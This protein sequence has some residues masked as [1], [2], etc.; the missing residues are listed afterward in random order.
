MVIDRGLFLR[1]TECFYNTRKKYYIDDNGEPVLYELMVSDRPCFSDGGNELSDWSKAV[2]NVEAY[3]EAAE[4]LLLGKLPKGGAFQPKPKGKAELLDA[5]R[6]RARR[7][8]FDYAI[9][10]RFDYFITLTLA[11]DKINRRDYRAVI[12]KLNTFLSNRVQ[13]F[14]LS[15]LGVPEYHRDGSLHFHFA[16]GN[17]A[18]AFKLIDSGT[19]SVDGHKKPIKVSTADRL[20]IPDEQRHPVYNISDWSLGFS[21]AI[22]TYGDRGALAAYLSKE[23]TKDCQKRLVNSGSIDKIGGRWYYHSNNLSKPLCVLGSSSYADS[24]GYSYDVQCDGGSFKVYKISSKGEI[25]K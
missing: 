19:V 14:G 22:P 16:V 8:V 2:D 5:S 1:R 7:K 12:K 13:R 25:L 15:Y 18:E 11:P 17:G 10:N 6:R 20:G 4:E 3:R 21:T 23:L 24:V 9:C